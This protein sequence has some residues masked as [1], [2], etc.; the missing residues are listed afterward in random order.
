[1]EDVTHIITVIVMAIAEVVTLITSCLAL[2]GGNWAETVSEQGDYFA[3][4]DNRQSISYLDSN[5]IHSVGMW[6]FFMMGDYD[7]TPLPIRDPE[8]QMGTA[9]YL[10]SMASGC[11]VITIPSYQILGI[12]PS[13]IIMS[14]AVFWISFFQVVFLLTAALVV[15]SY[16][17]NTFE[18]QSFG[19]SHSLAWVSFAFSLCTF[20]AAT[21]KLYW[22]LNR[23]K[24]EPDT[25]QKIKSPENTQRLREMSP[26]SVLSEQREFSGPG[27]RGEAPIDSPR[28][29]NSMRRMSFED[30]PPSVPAPMRP[31]Y[32]MDQPY[33]RA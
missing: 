10:L 24:H 20:A 13:C 7:S 8:L 30:R 33:S 21:F 19:Y 23:H 14:G 5:R 2:G 31:D 22:T 16:F 4:V 6:R 12:R 17:Q 32:Y 15:G 26:R 1:M 27:M 11:L 29:L 3:R 18:Y 25:D 9:I 28:S